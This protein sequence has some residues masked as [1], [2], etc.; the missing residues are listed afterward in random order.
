MKKQIFSRFLAA[1]LIV[2]GLFNF[3][4]KALAQP[5]APV[6]NIV[7]VH[8]AFADR[9]GWQSVYKLLTEKGYHTT[10]VQIP[11]TSLKEDV[12]ALNRALD[13]LDGPAVLVGHSWSGTVITEAGLHRNAAALVYIAAFQPDA[14]ENTFQ[15]V[16]S[17]PAAPESGLLPPDE[18][19]F[20]YYDK[21][22][23]HAGFAADISKEQASFM[24][25]AQQPIAAAAFGTPVTVAAWKT[26][27]SYAI[28][29]TEDK[30]INPS[31]QRAMFK[32]SNTPVKEIKSSHAVFISHAKEV[33]DYIMTAAK[34]AK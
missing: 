14:G 23:F 25:D 34:G 5:A 21:A 3:S 27:P 9:S 29:T 28:V 7:L 11:L 10:I 24:A 2:T 1:M 22:K 12:D 8:G 20:V 31:I 18:K 30:S 6:K 4:D 16:S 26:K 19:G 32:R 33:A 17:A 13:K 15:W